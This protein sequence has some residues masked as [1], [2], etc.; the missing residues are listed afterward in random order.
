[1]PSRIAPAATRAASSPSASIAAA[2]AKCVIGLVRRNR[3]AAVPF[4]RHAE[5]QAFAHRRMPPQLGLDGFRR[6]LAAGDVDPVAHVVTFPALTINHAVL[7]HAVR[8]I[9]AGLE[10]DAYDPNSPGSPLTLTFDRSARRFLMPVTRY[11]IGGPV[12]VYEVYVDVWH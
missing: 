12:D 11:F 9:A 1:M 3:F 8:A 2:T 7:L 4:L 5:D 6:D 10:F